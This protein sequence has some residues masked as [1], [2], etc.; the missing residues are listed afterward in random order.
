MSEGQGDDKRPVVFIG[1]M[2]HFQWNHPRFRS[3]KHRGQV[4]DDAA[5]VFL[6][7]RRHGYW[8]CRVNNIGVSMPRVAPYYGA[9][10]ILE[11]LAI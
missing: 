6:W 9:V 2:D 3:V 7:R 5:A 11:L 4:P 10:G 1:G 8:A